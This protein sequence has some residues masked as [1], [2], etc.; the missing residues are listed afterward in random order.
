[1]LNPNI[2]TSGRRWWCGWSIKPMVIRP[3]D[4]GTKRKRARDKMLLRNGKVDSMCKGSIA[5]IRRGLGSS[6]NLQAKNQS[7]N[8]LSFWISSDKFCH[9][10]PQLAFDTLAFLHR[11]YVDSECKPRIRTYYHPWLVISCYRP[12]FSPYSQFVENGCAYFNSEAVCSGS[13]QIESDVSYTITTGFASGTRA[14]ACLTPKWQQ[15]WSFPLADEGNYDPDVF[16]SLKDDYC[17]YSISSSN[18]NGGKLPHQS[19][20]L[21][22]MD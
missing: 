19:H 14:Y 22:S 13:I 5:F 3:N 1:M 2:F 15:R 18:E 17:I 9:G 10:S 20:L 4:D 7:I 11:I 6:Q 8:S 16:F 21:L 12:L